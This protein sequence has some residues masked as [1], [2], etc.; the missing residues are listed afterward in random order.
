MASNKL[1]INSLKTHVMVFCKKK[2]D[3]EREEVKVKAGLH[4][5]TPSKTETLLG[6]KLCQ[7]LG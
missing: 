7:D 2:M 1:V 3:Q 5:V 6:A 4:E